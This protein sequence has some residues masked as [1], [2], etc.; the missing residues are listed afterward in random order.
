MRTVRFVTGVVIVINSL[1]AAAQSAR[2]AG[3]AAPAS[4]TLDSNWCLQDV[5][6]ATESGAFISS[7]GYDDSSWYAAT[8]PG[9]VL[10]S[11]VNDGVYPEPLYG[12]NDRPWS[13]P[14]SLNKTSYWYRTVAAIPAN[15][16]GRHIWLNF[17]GINFT[18]HVWVNGTE[19]GEIQGAFTRGRFD[20]SPDVHA[21]R[22]AVIAVL[23]TPQ[24]HPGTP[25]E[26]TLL[27][28]IG[29]NGG[30]SAI[31]GPTFLSSIGWDWL[32]AIHDRESGIW[33]KVY[34]SAS[35]DA[36]VENPYITSK[37]PL[38]R[39]DSADLSVS[40]TVENV[41]AKTLNGT[42]RGEISTPGATPIYFNEPVTL[43]ANQSKLIQLDSSTT[44]ALHVSHPKLWWPNGYGAHPLYMLKLTFIA[45]GHVSDV[46]STTFGIRQIEYTA[47][48]SD[49]LTISVNGV[50]V[51]IRGGDWG[52]DEGLKRI[53]Y[54][55]L[56]DKIRLHALA[57]LNLIRNWVGQS[58]SE[59]F[60]DLCDKY[61]ILVWDE[62]FQPNPGDG[63]NPD[64]MA[65]YM[66]NVRDKVLRFR[67]HPSIAIWCGR[68][69][70][71][72]PKDIDDAL[73]TMMAQLDPVRLYQPSS[74]DGRGV[75][76][77][78]PYRWRAPEEFYVFPDTEAF[79]TEIGSVS[80]PTLD[81]VHHMMPQ[82]DWETINDDW[83]EH[84]FAKGNSGAEDYPAEMTARYG[85]ILNLADFVRKAQ[86]MNFEAFRAMYEGR[87]AKMWNTTTA[88]ITWMSN[89]AQPSFVWQIYGYDYDPMSS[90]FAVKDASE[91]IHI[92]WNEA[93]DELETI[94]NTP[95]AFHGMVTWTIYALDGTKI[96]TQQMPVDA[97]ADNITRLSTLTNPATPAGV[98]FVELEL[99][100]ADGKLVSRNVYWRAPAATRD[101][102]TSM[103]AMPKVELTATLAQHRALHGEIAYTITLMNPTP[104]MAV[105]AHVTLRRLGEPDN[106]IADNR[107]LPAFYSDNYVT[108]APGESEP[109]TITANAADLEG[110]K[111]LITLDG[112]NTGLVATEGAGITA[113]ENV[114]AEPS[115]WPI[116]HLPYATRALILSPSDA[117]AAKPAVG[118]T[119]TPATQP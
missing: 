23:I 43:E 54:A 111:P 73:R 19:V 13:I 68:N 87:N 7:S 37:L 109:I 69:E 59:D 94:N 86:M 84:D 10:T 60:Y 66:A 112:W 49:N 103:D 22:K 102:L 92:Q 80:V 42:L 57:N 64:D 104:H 56:E 48:G 36:L 18:A 11:L 3:P 115:H 82:K 116:T 32:P 117:P 89:P 75:I 67:D 16:A 106:A 63:P 113:R 99:H 88:V 25:H 119:A 71:Y 96:S 5:S 45:D 24:P 72:P 108:L 62:F 29:G 76:S 79:K 39:T 15:Y 100:G 27:A 9:T 35:G 83:A 61:G 78:G 20:I 34:L 46:L 65:I 17:D 74:T 21:G 101:D 95:A 98:H 51:F 14:E 40:A 41:A 53:S 58:T 12:E 105:M 85:P 81:G 107:V 93:T 1:F 38:P 31:D 91:P 110:A 70:G 55:R 52:L 114:D 28:G 77:H 90:F 2:R 50:K 97:A 8:V 4:V 6:K 44:P 30:E 47:P 26:H 33:Q 118:T